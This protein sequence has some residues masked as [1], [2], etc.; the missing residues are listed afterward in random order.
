MKNRYEW[1]TGSTVTGQMQSLTWKQRQWGAINKVATTFVQDM[2]WDVTALVVAKRSAVAQLNYFRQ[3]FGMISASMASLSCDCYDIPSNMASFCS[4]IG[5]ASEDLASCLAAQGAAVTCG[6]AYV[7]NVTDN[8]Q[9]TVGVLPAYKVLAA[10]SPLIEQREGFGLMAVGNSATYAIVKNDNDAVV[11]QVVGDAKVVSGVTG[12]VNLCIDKNPN[13]DEDT[14]S[15]PVYDFAPYANNKVGPPQGLTITENGLQLC[16]DVTAGTTYYPVLR[17][18][19]YTTPTGGSPSG[20]LSLK[21]NLLSLF[22]A[23]LLAVL[24]ARA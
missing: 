6:G 20:A 23:A 2:F 16:A 12:T 7:G 14:S 4:S 5:S 17:F 19:D 21:A 9:I 15:Y 18:T 10:A 11:G 3:K 8:T 1:T 13:I 22:V 24:F